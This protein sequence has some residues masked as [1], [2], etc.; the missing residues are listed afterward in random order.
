M[1]TNASLLNY[2]EIIVTYEK[3]NQ[4]IFSLTY[5]RRNLNKNITS[6]LRPRHPLHFHLSFCKNPQSK[7]KLIKIKPLCSSSNTLTNQRQ[8]VQTS[9]K[10]Q[11]GV[12][13]NKCRHHRHATPLI[14]CTWSERPS[15]RDFYLPLHTYLRS[16]KPAESSLAWQ[17]KST[18]LTFPSVSFTNSL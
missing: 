9:C 13:F 14:F 11:D 16:A 4:I 3:L 18:E 2:Y 7:L 15:L 5:Y 10:I 1:V 12:F 17:L 6:T 8:H